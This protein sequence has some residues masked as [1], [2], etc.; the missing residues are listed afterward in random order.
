ME[1]L[2][3]AALALALGLAAAPAGA[4]DFDWD[5]IFAPYRQRI[6]TATTSSGNAQDVNAATQVITPWPPYVH[7]RHIPGNGARQVGAIER[8]RNPLQSS[9]TMQAPKKAQ[10]AVPEMG[11]TPTNEAGGGGAQSGAPG[12]ASPS[13]K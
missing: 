5:D 11:G 10:A 12:Q 9:G 6:D 1:A 13:E 8:Y 4:G 7:N 3:T 2:K